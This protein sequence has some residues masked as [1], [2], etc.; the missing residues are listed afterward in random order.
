MHHSTLRTIRF[1]LAAA[2]LV[3]AA[4]AAARARDTTAA[5]PAMLPPM[6]TSASS[7]MSEIQRNIAD[8]ASLANMSSRERYLR[9]QKDNRYLEQV[10]RDQDKSIDRL[11]RRLAEL[12]TQREKQRAEQA[13]A[14]VTLAGEPT[15]EARMMKLERTAPPQK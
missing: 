2:A 1:V 14:K 12:K 15:L 10:L 5:K 6:V 7:F 8:S 9:L 13:D 4:P 3:A 11:E